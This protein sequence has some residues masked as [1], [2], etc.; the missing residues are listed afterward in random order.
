FNLVRGGKSDW[1]LPSSGELAAIASYI[2]NCVNG[3]FF[4]ERF[5]FN[6][7]ESV[8]SVYWSSSQYAAAYASTQRFSNGLDGYFAKDRLLRVRPIRSF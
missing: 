7:T 8:E 2:K 5:A 1:F 6:E 4:H 3:C